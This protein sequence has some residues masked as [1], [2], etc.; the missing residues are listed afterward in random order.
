[1]NYS[2]ILKSSIFAL[3][4]VFSG[5]LYGANPH[6]AAEAVDSPA[7]A[8][9]LVLRDLWVEHISWVRNYVIAN[10]LDNGRSGD[11][12]QTEIVANAREIANAIAPLYG[13]DAADQLFAL[14]G[15]HWGAIKAYADASAHEN[16]ARVKAASSDLVDNATAIAEFLSTANPYLPR[17]TLVSLL[18]AHGAQHIQQIQ[19]IED[20]DFAGEAITWR[21]MRTHILVI[22]DALVAALVKQFP[23]KF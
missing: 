8:T 16:A 23:E 15:G 4:L 12:A 1:M 6:V 20:Q 2:Q 22:S 19:Q 7:L 17:E 11:T 5:V 14:L 18:S 3:S 10:S 9:R 13:Q 21:A